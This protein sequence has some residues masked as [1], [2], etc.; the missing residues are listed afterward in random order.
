MFEYVLRF[1]L[2]TFVMFSSHN[3]S[4]YSDGVESSFYR[5]W[6]DRRDFGEK[7]WIMERKAATKGQT[8]GQFCTITDWWL[9]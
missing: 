3:Q 8:P 7:G 4:I 1:Y 5:D 6:G 2:F 9:R